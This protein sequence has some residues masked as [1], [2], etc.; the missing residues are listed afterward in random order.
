MDCQNPLEAPS[1]IPQ[2]YMGKEGLALLHLLCMLRAVL[3]WPMVNDTATW[4]VT[5]ET[6]PAA[7]AVPLALL[8]SE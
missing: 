5:S 4:L 2:S 1:N 6:Q 3:G 7:S 8:I